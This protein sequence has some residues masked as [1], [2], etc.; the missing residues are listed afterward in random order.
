MGCHNEGARVVTATI[1]WWVIKDAVGSGHGTGVFHFYSF[2][3]SHQ[4]YYPLPTMPPF[5]NS[6]MPQPNI[7]V[8]GLHFP[9]A[10]VENTYARFLSSTLKKLCSLLPTHF[11]TNWIFSHK[12]YL[13]KNITKSTTRLPVHGSKIGQ[14]VPA[15]PLW[16]LGSW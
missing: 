14:P 16:H 3:I 11:R 1:N 13:S 10:M 9:V 7:I 8:E 2:I 12:K 5:P 6:L 4:F 15:L